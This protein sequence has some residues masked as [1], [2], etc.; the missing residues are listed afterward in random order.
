MARRTVPTARPRPR[1]QVRDR[2]QLR[3]DRA[4]VDLRT[5]LRSK[6]LVGMLGRQGVDFQDS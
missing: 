5:Q 1:G 4:T 6:L 2:G 3:R